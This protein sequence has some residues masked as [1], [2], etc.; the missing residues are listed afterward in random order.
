MRCRKKVNDALSVRNKASDLDRAQEWLARRL[1]GGPVK[2]DDCAE[3]GNKALGL[4]KPGKWW[5]LSVLKERLGGKSRKFGFLAGACW[6]FTLPGHPWP[7]RV[8]SSPSSGQHHPAT[9]TFP[10]KTHEE[11]EDSRGGCKGVDSSPSSGAAARAARAAEPARYEESEGGEEGEES[12][13]ACEGSGGF[14]GDD[15]P[16]FDDVF[17]DG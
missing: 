11:G 8:D 9:L 16:L 15:G 1:A 14:F 6:Y 3:E 17:A 7:P 12:K 13:G 5:N 10:S 4:N 2:S